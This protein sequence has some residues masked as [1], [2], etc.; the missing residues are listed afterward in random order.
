MRELL[1]DFYG[2]VEQEA[3]AHKGVI[4]NFMGDGAM[5]VFGLPE[6]S[7]DDPANALRCSVA[8]AAHA[9]AWLTRSL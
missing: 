7:P 6:P 5:I 8:L 4:T 1:D 2:L 9:R 3:E